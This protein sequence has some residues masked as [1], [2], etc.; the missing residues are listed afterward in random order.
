MKKLLMWLLAVAG[1]ITL[2]AALLRSLSGGSG[3]EARAEELETAQK[4][5]ELERQDVAEAVAQSERSARSI[6]DVEANDGGSYAQQL[7]DFQTRA[8]QFRDLYQDFVQ[9]TQSYSVKGRNLIDTMKQQAGGIDSTEI[10]ELDVR[11]ESKIRSVERSYS[12]ELRRQRQELSGL[13]R[14]VRQAEALSKLCDV[15]L[16]AQSF[17]ELLGEAQR[18]T[19]EIRSEAN[20]YAKSA[21]RL[22]RLLDATPTD[23]D[24]EIS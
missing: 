20:A 3:I 4:N 22:L 18:A 8:S 21:D 14:Q 9:R 23:A 24:R 13:E 16:G 1:S 12:A 11:A 7:K 17:G 19:Q 2:G 10:P 6:A 5:L 15:E